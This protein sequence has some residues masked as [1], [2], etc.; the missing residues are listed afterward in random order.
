MVFESEIRFK[1]VALE[2]MNWLTVFFQVQP[3]IDAV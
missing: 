2:E 1:I 3:V